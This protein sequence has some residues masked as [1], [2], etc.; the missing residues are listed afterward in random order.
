MVHALEI[1]HGLLKKGGLFIDIHPSGRPPRVEVHNGGQ[2]QLA[3]HLEEINDFVEYAQA[4]EALKQVTNRG[5]FQLESQRLF[6]FLLHAPTIKALADYLE[7]EWLDSILPEEVVERL[8]TL[9]DEMGEAP[10]D[11]KEIVVRE[12]IGISR[13]RANG[14]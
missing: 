10:G 3:G 1:I 7:A 6:D 9:L 4:D 14:L 13:F 12:N 2:I 8:A 5:L 11:D